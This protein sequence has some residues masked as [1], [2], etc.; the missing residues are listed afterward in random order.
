M[1]N[2]T[3]FGKFPFDV[4]LVEVD[5][6]YKIPKELRELKEWT[7]TRTYS[8]AFYSSLN[9]KYKS[10]KHK[11]DFICHFPSKHTKEGFFSKVKE[12]EIIYKK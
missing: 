5:E 3:V 11:V 12:S 8:R 7:K 10:N 2:D 9:F 4:E 6:L 1:N